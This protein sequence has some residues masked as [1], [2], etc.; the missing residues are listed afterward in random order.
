MS[1]IRGNVRLYV[2]IENAIFASMCVHIPKIKKEIK[3]RYR[4]LE[5]IAKKR[6]FL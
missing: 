3:L 4:K 5:R 2:P 6:K 1:I